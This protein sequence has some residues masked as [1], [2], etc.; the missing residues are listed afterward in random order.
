MPEN[1][2]PGKWSYDDL[3]DQKVE[4]HFGNDPHTRLGEFVVSKDPDN[5]K[6]AVRIR[7]FLR[8]WEKWIER[9]LLLHPHHIARIELHPENPGDD[10]AKPKFRLFA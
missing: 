2:P 1:E 9:Q 7:F 6:L 4:F 3:Q 10:P 8:E 5:G